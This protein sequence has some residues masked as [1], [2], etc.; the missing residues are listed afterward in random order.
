MNSVHH[1]QSCVVKR[2]RQCKQKQNDLSYVLLTSET[3]S[4]INHS[5]YYGSDVSLKQLKEALKAGTN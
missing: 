4:Q 3:S 2:P 5:Q 1:G